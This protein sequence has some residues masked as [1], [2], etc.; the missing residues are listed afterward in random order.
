MTVVV[1]WPGER[2]EAEADQERDPDVELEP[3]PDLDHLIVRRSRPADLGGGVV[4]VVG[5]DVLVDRRADLRRGRS[6][7]RA[8][9]HSGEESVDLLL[10]V[11]QQ[12]GLQPGLVEIVRGGHAVEAG[13]RGVRG[14]FVACDQA[15]HHEGQSHERDGDG[16]AGRDAR[17][18]EGQP[19]PAGDDQVAEHAVG[20]VGRPGRR[21]ESR[22]GDEPELVDQVGGLGEKLRAAGQR[23]AVRIDRVEQQPEAVEQDRRHDDQ[24]HHGDHEAAA[25]ADLQVLGGD[26]IPG[27]Q[28]GACPRHPPPAGRGRFGSSLGQRGLGGGHD[29]SP[30]RL[31]TDKNQSSSDVW[32]SRRP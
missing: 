4:A 11:L 1:R 15:V 30:S 31:V 32:T 14:A 5:R 16:Q 28:P 12:E 9:G 8:A 27:G 23:I 6:G 25:L 29:G 26:E 3:Q 2:A 10:G 13:R 24:H 20:Q 18:V 21:A 19:G 17:Q 7:P 22:G